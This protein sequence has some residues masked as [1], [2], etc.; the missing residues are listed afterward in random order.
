MSGQWSALNDELVR[1][2]SNKSYRPYTS[3]RLCLK[4][5]HF[6]LTGLQPGVSTDFSPQNFG[7]SYN[8][9]GGNAPL[10]NANNNVVT[11]GGQPVII[12]ITASQL[13]ATTSV[14]NTRE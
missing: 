6:I 5:P 7:G 3:E 10:L 2:S 8:F 12:S 4:S 14:T 13:I 11:A 9:S 1:H